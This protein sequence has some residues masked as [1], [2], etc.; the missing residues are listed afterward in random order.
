MGIIIIIILVI[1]LLAII[2]KKLFLI[3][4]ISLIAFVIIFLC[5]SAI[6]RRRV[7]KEESEREQQYVERDI[8]Y[9]ENTI[10]SIPSHSNNVEIALQ[11]FESQGIGG[12]IGSEARRILNSCSNRQEV[13][14]KAIE[15]CGENPSTP[16]ALYVVSSCYVWLGAKY[17]PQAIEYLEKYLDVGLFCEPE[18]AIYVK[19]SVYKYLGEAYEGEY[20]F[21]KAEQ[22]YLTAE[23]ICPDTP[24]HVV[25]TSR[26][27]IKKGDLQRALNHLEATKSSVYYRKNINDYKTVIDSYVDDVKMKIS[28]GYVY[29]PRKK[30]QE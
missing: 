8:R 28:K 25:D 20:E 11:L 30:K 1:G 3:V 9:E 29:R 24:C 15:M 4:A 16:K 10:N 21:D 17:R 23:K 26:I 6:N 13:L 5:I 7:K 12:E 27:Y 19:A 2:F 18:N 22:A 14:L